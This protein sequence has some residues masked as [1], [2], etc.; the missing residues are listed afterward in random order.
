MV[1]SPSG[2][3]ILDIVD[4]S[5]I[6]TFVNKLGSILVV[7]SHLLL[8]YVQLIRSQLFYY[9]CTS[10]CYRQY[11]H[12]VF[13]QAYN[14]RPFSIPDLRILLRIVFINTPRLFWQAEL[15]VYNRRIRC[16]IGRCGSKCVLM[17]EG[18]QGQSA[19]ARRK[20][21]YWNGPHQPQIITHTWR[22]QNIGKGTQATE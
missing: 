15:E 5:T 16:Q 20:Q 8:V 1:G 21:R 18:D 12:S 9:S 14:I 19:A 6:S 3:D 13:V 17:C 11:S 4:S 10:L 2:Q 22:G 7:C